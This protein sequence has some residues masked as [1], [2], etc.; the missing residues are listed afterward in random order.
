MRSTV[1]SWVSWQ[2]RGGGAK[3]DDEHLE[4]LQKP[5]QR[6]FWNVGALLELSADAKE[7]A[8][9]QAG[10]MPPT[11]GG[12][13]GALTAVKPKRRFLSIPKSPPKFLLT[14][15]S[16]EEEPMTASGQPEE[17][18]S[19][20]TVSGVAR[21]WWANLRESMYDVVDT[22][23]TVEDISVNNAETLPVPQKVIEKVE[24]REV[25]RRSVESEANIEIIKKR[26][27]ARNQEVSQLQI[28][29]I[30]PGDTSASEQM[31]VNVDTT[32]NEGVAAKEKEETHVASVTLENGSAIEPKIVEEKTDIVVP[33]NLN[34]DAEVGQMSD[35]GDD[36]ESEQDLGPAIV[37]GESPYMSSGAWQAIDKILSLGLS[38]G[39][40][41]L[42][43]SRHLRPMRKAIA[44]ATGLHGV[45]SGKPKSGTLITQP[46]E[47]MET[48]DEEDLGLIRR[49]IAAIDR[50]RKSVELK[51][52]EDAAGEQEG[53]GL[54]GRRRKVDEWTVVIPELSTDKDVPNEDIGV[55]IQEES[56]DD[57]EAR[58]TQERVMEIDR[59]IKQSQAR[60]LELACEKDALQM[61]PN[62]LY[63]YTTTKGGNG[64]VKFSREF[65]FPSETLVEDYLDDLFAHGR[66]IKM[67]HTHLWKSGVGFDDDEDESIGDDLLTPS[68]DASRLYSEYPQKISPP[69]ER[70]SVNGNGGGGSWILRQ[71]IGKGGSLGEKIGEAAEIAG[72]KAVCTAV[73]SSLARSISAIHGMNIMD[74]S[75][76]R[77][78]ME[79]VP[80]LP[81]LSRTM[82]PRNDYAEEAIKG[83]MMK[84]RKRKKKGGMPKLSEEAFIQRDAIVETLLSHCQISAPL[85]K[86]FPLAWQR[87]L[88]ANMITLITHVI[89][90][91]AEGIELQILGHALT[92]SFKPITESD[93]IRHIGLADK[94]INHRRTKPEE[95]EAAVMATA[96]DVS[97][98]LKILDRWHERALGS[99]MLRAQ[100]ANLIARLVLTLADEVLSG[101]RM[102][103]WA[104]QA[105]GPRVLGGLEYR[106]TP[107]PTPA[108]TQTEQ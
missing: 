87:A 27:A 58:R 4:D 70:R 68:A 104:A 91:F 72:Y 39:S 6:R 55:R 51:Q 17:Q 78:F 23:A 46:E 88:L 99:G 65:S 74:H 64:T 20:A 81:P 5:K 95:F 60:L 8:A 12:R 67:N 26:A 19:A 77:L 83:A 76:I 16:K 37:V 63:N 85:L 50:A 13:G 10:A 86:L 48:L 94:G 22:E 2:G 62:P 97:Q 49:R 107:T 29:K 35:F 28:E 98:G 38:N 90:D 52:E 71:S 79:Q 89:S 80:D 15:K 32:K 53:R 96:E 44:K 84:S 108:P 59:L 36:T 69:F 75:D 9:L 3:E 73:M 101:A 61:R 42:R 18:S 7:N 54:F 57:A 34:G 33:S 1:M 102:D 105:G 56:F 93:M 31:R 82:L 24:R 45:V 21:F 106:T 43:F 25:S 100:I 40:P 103:L 66:L 30:E 47:E 11:N 92:F 41:Q 14:F